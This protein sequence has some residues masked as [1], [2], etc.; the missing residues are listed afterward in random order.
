MFF[1]LPSTTP[2]ALAISQR[3]SLARVKHCLA[4]LQT[5]SSSLRWTLSVS[6]T[7]LEVVGRG[8][9]ENFTNLFSLIFWPLITNTLV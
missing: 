1:F 4:S 5:P 6:S 3:G 7:H 8:S 9:K 2:N